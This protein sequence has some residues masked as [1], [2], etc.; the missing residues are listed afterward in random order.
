MAIA[1]KILDDV[2]KIIRNLKKVSKTFDRK[3]QRKLLRPGAVVIQ[4]A[5]KAA[6]P[7]GGDTSYRYQTSKIDKDKRA[8]K[9][10][11]N[12]VAAL[13][14]GNFQRSIRLLFFTRSSGIFVGPK[15]AKGNR[16]GVFSGSRVDGYTAH[17]TE[18]GTVNYQ[19][20]HPIRNGY[21]SSK[22]AAL[23]AIN[24][25]GKQIMNQLTLF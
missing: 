17:W 22:G 6:S 19:G 16:T 11:G 2:D 3:G 5:I 18:Y 1:N 23:V 7:F 21:E 10:S 20:K 9:G 25:K 12:V 4:K 14:P 13:D 8:P 15:V 24:M